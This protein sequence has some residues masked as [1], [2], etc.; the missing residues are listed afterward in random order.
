MFLDLTL[1][2]AKFW[3]N[4]FKDLCNTT[5]VLSIL[6]KVADG[7]L[8]QVVYLCQ[9]VSN[10]VHS[11]FAY[12]SNISSACVASHTAQRCYIVEKCIPITI[13]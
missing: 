1:R 10:S 4:I 12:H 5:A 8:A 9:T 6:L 3:C 7:E 11:A 13:K 2:I